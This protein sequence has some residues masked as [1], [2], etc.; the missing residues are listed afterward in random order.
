MKWFHACILLSIC[1][2]AMTNDKEP[3]TLI[4]RPIVYNIILAVVD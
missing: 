3:E 2:L 1:I 4:N